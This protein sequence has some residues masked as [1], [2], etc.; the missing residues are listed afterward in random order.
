MKGMMEPVRSMGFS[1]RQSCLSSAS[2]EQVAR[3][4]ERAMWRLGSLRP[5]RVS[6]DGSGPMVRHLSGCALRLKR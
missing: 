4:S 2:S 6:R 5:P 3:A 1:M